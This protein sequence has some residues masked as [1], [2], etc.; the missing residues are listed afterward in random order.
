MHWASMFAVAGHQSIQFSVAIRHSTSA[1]CSAHFISA[2]H[3]CCIMHYGASIISELQIR[4]LYKLV[5]LQ[6]CVPNSA[7]Q[8]RF[9]SSEIRSIH[10]GSGASDT[11]SDGSI[12]AHSLPLAHQ[13]NRLQRRLPLLCIQHSLLLVE[14]LTDKISH[15]KR[16]SH[17]GNHSRLP[18]KSLFSR[19]L[20]EISPLKTTPANSFSLS[21]SLSLSLP[22]SHQCL[23]RHISLLMI[24][25]KVFYIFFTSLPVRLY[26]PSD[27][28]WAPHRAVRRF[29][30]YTKRSMKNCKSSAQR[31]NS[32]AVE[33]IQ[34]ISSEPYL[35]FST[36]WPLSCQ[37]ANTRKGQFWT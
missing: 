13:Q 34:Q 24:A 5:A 36:R 15:A 11:V 2:P 29:E 8:A 9:L 21:L 27:A 32:F 1:A 16:R 19:V 25:A 12:Q 37:S 23:V 30:C 17:H 6:H 20:K 3:T 31:F 22:L 28:E 33:R 26:W 10:M 35:M 14:L 18:V 4:A 7:A